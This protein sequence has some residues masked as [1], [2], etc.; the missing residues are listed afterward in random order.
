MITNIIVGRTNI[1]YMEMIKYG[2]V[3]A[4]IGTA[5]SIKYPLIGFTL[6]GMG[7]GAGMIGLP[8]AVSHMNIKKG[9]AMGFF[10]TCT[11]AGLGMMPIFFGLFLNTLGF[12][13]IFSISALV[14]FLSTFLKD[15]LKAN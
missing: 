14:L 5:I 7:S 3:V 6:I 15:G 8:I 12:Q 10:N 1:K 4:A 11:Y 2:I 13:L 9:L